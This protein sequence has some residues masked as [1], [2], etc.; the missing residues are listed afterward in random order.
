MFPSIQLSDYHVSRDT[1]FLLE[2][3]QEYLPEYFEPWNRL[4]KCMPDLVSSHS[5]REAVK[6][7]PLLDYSKL[8]G[9]RQKRLAHMQLVLITSGYLWQEGDA[10]VVQR[11]PECV[12]VPL[13]HVS[14]ILGLKPVISHPALCL[15]N[16][17]YTKDQ[18][19]IE[20]LYTVPGGSDSVWFFKV[21]CFVEMAFA[22][23]VQAV[24]N[25]LD[26][27]LED[28]NVKVTA[29]LSGLTETVGNMQSAMKR[30][31]EHLSSDTFYNT[32]RP[33]L[34]GW[35]GPSSPLPDGL[36]FEGVSEEPVQVVGGSA[37][38]S[39]TLQL[40][41]LLL[42][43]THSPDKQTFLD[44]MRNYM[45]PAHKQLLVD[46]MNMPRK[47]TFMVEDS[48]DTN[49]TTAYNKCLTALTQFR[50]YHV[51]VVTKYVVS[52]S[53]KENRENSHLANKGTG[54]TDLLP[55]LKA[56]RDDTKKKVNL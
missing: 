26:G 51:Q 1:G 12:A 44:E 10:G 5:M 39:S 34:G 14:N 13:W 29:G 17:K 56:L 24:Q 22:K 11:L 3:P 36:I 31:H 47:L 28:D 15:A 9:Y 45:P 19:D 27:V 6:E 4:A 49:L 20:V 2:N 25:V 43:V 16:W 48:E 40:T 52:A 46:V 50:S 18:G 37:A 7:M 38:Q 42:G 23:G 41:D 53:K 32:V 35:G 21:T 55:F 54:G 30:M 33:Y 8:A